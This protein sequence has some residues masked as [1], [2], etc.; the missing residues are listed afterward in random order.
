[1]NYWL[2]LDSWKYNHIKHPFL[3]KREYLLQVNLRAE[4][5]I[6]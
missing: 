1:M 4:E 5:Y 6:E 3:V 2:F